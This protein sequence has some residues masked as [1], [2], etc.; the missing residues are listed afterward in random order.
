[1]KK[2]LVFTV[3]LVLTVL[4]LYQ[5]QGG[6]EG[7][8]RKVLPVFPDYPEPSLAL[9]ENQSGEI[10]FSSSTPFD[11]DVLLNDPA[12][13]IA[14]TG[15]GTLF[16]PVD[17][18]ADN[19]VPAMILLHGSGGISPG[20]EMEYAQLLSDNGY[21][22]FVINYYAP[23]GASDD[24]PYMLRV[25]SITEFDAV[26]DGYAGLKI[27]STHPAIDPARIGLMGF[28]YG[29]MA[30]RFAMDERVRERLVP[31]LPGFA[32]FVDYYG[33]C[34]QSLGTTETNGAPLLTLRGTEDKSNDLAACKKREGE[35]AAMGV[36]VEA[37]IFEGAGHAWENT[38]QRKL[39]ESAPYV[40][41]C[42]ITYDENGNS[43][44][45]EQYI[46]NVPLATSREKRI[47]MRMSS[48]DAMMDCV[49]Y[50]YLIGNDAVT[51]VKSDQRLLDFLQRVLKQSLAVDS[52]P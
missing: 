26:V 50:G 20:R 11:F 52:G 31:Q 38:A 42:E 15:L 1:M 7:L 43:M 8:V 17:A 2:W 37:H 46:V 24:T 28:S 25:I 19:P 6:R 21:A 36:S 5:W 32:G 39:K 18:S 45:G 13:G 35:L 4:G 33:P 51:K 22:A 12:V 14:T 30:T 10:Y 48:G 16:L 49:H 3:A 34:F 44:I 41:G 29:A 23:R 9:S 27:L 40:Q 47:A